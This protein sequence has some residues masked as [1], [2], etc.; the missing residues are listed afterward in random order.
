MLRTG[1]AARLAAGPG[2]GIRRDAAPPTPPP[3]PARD[4]RGAAAGRPG[5]RRPVGQDALRRRSVR[6]V[7]DGRPVALPPRRGRPGRPAALP[8]ADVDGGL[9]AGLRAERLER[10]G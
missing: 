10:G 6:A 5:R 3:R 2:V 4:A 9:V 7:P 1:T 8:A